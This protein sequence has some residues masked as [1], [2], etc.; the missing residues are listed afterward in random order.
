MDSDDESITRA[1]RYILEF[2]YETD[3]I[4][5]PKCIAVNIGPPDGYNPSYVGTRCRRLEE[6]GLL[7]QSHQTMYTLTSKGKRYLTDELDSGDEA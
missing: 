7:E 4:L 1:E 5:S 2:L 3:A 6:R